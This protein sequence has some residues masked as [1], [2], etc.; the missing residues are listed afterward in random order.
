[1]AA[2]SPSIRTP[3]SL[4]GAMD[5]SILYLSDGDVA[6]L[7][8]DLDALREAVAAAFAA[9]ARDRAGASEKSTIVLGP[10]HIFQAKPG[11]LLDAGLVG[12]KWFGLVPAGTTAEPSIDSVILVS[13]VDSGKLTAIVAGNWITAKRTAAMS[14]IAARWLARPASATIGFIGAGV[15]GRSHLEALVRVLPDLARVVVCS[16]TL[17]SASRLADAARGMGLAATVTDDPRDAVLGMDVVVTTVPEGSWRGSPLDPDWV[18]PGAFVAAVD[19]A[20]SWDRARLRQFEVLVT[21]DHE[22]TRALTATGR[23]TYAGPYEA[24]LADLCSGRVVGRNSDTQR[25][26]F[27][28]SGHALADLASAQVAIG[29]ARAAGIG[30]RLRR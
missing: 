18:A 1:M 16:R 14:A 3:A 7:G 6:G 2:P 21:D 29:T 13:D 26:L 25:A 15:Q 30:T 27:N 20:R 5:D 17:T 9:K 24:D 12:M 22:Q 4:V 8:L 11:S 10:A 19:L 23:M 28:F